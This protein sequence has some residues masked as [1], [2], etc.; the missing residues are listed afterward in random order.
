MLDIGLS[1]SDLLKEI[2]T[3]ELTPELI[4]D[5]IDKN[6]KAIYDQLESRGFASLVVDIVIDY[7]YRR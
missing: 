3:S 4:V 1:K 5:L 2:G 7:I 6:I